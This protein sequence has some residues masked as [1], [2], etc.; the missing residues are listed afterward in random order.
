MP[1]T[2]GQRLANA[3]KDAGLTLDELSNRTNIRAT[4]LKEFE[5]NR[6]QNA[7]GDT[8]ARGHLRN[9]AKAF[10]IDQDS[11]LL[12]FDEEHAQVARAIHEQLVENNAML[13]IPE[14]SKITQKQ[15]IAFSAI[16]IVAILGI[17][18]T[19]NSLK[20]SAESPKVVASASPSVSPSENLSPSASPSTN[21]YSSGTGVSVQLEATAGSSWLF[22]SDAAGVTL[23]SG[24]A[25]QGQ[26]FQFSSTESVN[27]RIGN[28]GAVK[29]TVNGKEVPPLGG[30]GEVVNVSYGVN[31]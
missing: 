11:F 4:L 17:S 23:Y 22:V 28:A 16:G 30:N 14:K 3:R 1:M 31:S 2:L 12:D 8:Y 27:L 18:L 6:F 9:I 29:L 7:G 25:T 13:P 20:Q 24:R 10:G 5:E 19:I 26:I 21:S 15:L